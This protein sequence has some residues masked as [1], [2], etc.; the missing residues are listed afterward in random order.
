MT[1]SPVA[2]SKGS[3]G[4]ALLGSRRTE[5]DV[6]E[7]SKRRQTQFC[8][9]AAFWLLGLINNSGYVIMM[10]VA[11]EIAPGAVG[12]VFLADVA[13]TMI[14]KVT[15]PYWFHL[16]PYSLRV[17]TCT[18]LL[19]LSLV[20]VGYGG[21]TAVQLAGVCFSSLQGGLGEA[22]FLALASF[23]DTPRALTAWSSGT[24][25]A[26]IFGYAWVFSLK[27]VLGL[28]FRATLMT[29]NLLGL[30]FLYAYF[31]L[32]SAP[33]GSSGQRRRGV[34]G[35][36]SAAYSPIASSQ[37]QELQSSPSPSGTADGGAR[38][39]SAASSEVVREEQEE[40]WGGGGEGGGLEVEASGV[41]WNRPPNMTVGE[42]LRFTLSLWRF[43]VPLMLVYF[44]EYTMQTGTWSAIGF[45][46]TSADA[47]QRFYEYANW[48]YQGG[49]FVSRSSGMVVRLSPLMLWSLPAVQLFYGNGLLFLCFGVG[50]V[51]GLG[52]V[53]AFR[54]VAEAVPPE[55]KELALASASVGDSFG[56][57]LSD[58]FGT[59]VQA[60]MPNAAAEAHKSAGNAFFKN[61]DYRNAIAKYSDAIAADPTN[62][63]YWSNRS[64]SYA[65]L[66][67]WEE[68][69]RDAAECIKVNKN[70]VKGYFRLAT[71]KKNLNELDAAADVIKRGLCVEP[72][73]A[74]LK[75]NLKEIDELIRGEKVA[76]FISQAEA[77]LKAGDYGAAMR[78]VDAGMR[79][80][81]G[82]SDLKAVMDRAKPKFEAAERSRK[83]GLSSTELLKEKGDDFYKKAS[84]EDA[85]AK[86]TECL[87]SLPD[88]KSEL[89]I[90]CFSNRS[91]CYKQLSNFD[92]TVEDTTSVLE[93]DPNNVKALV[94]RAQAFEAI[95]RYRFALQDVR[96]V[97][98]MPHDKVGSQ[99][100]SLA[101]GMQHRLN[102]VVQQLKNAS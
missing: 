32:L 17:W 2:D 13:P 44:A 8:N 27:F 30:V 15:A 10:A 80:D 79:L 92:A 43:T 94:R 36:T 20:T 9:D 61:G 19:V 29:A 59:F 49:V 47:R 95:E 87:D 57:M 66:N 26:G 102:R 89:A 16:V 55:L 78:A 68:A 21:S 58:V 31:R 1:L 88:K 45:P 98:S 28:S 96:T 23:Y 101:N 41:E 22:S 34:A 93:V 33:H 83:S 60:K 37:G 56:V 38:L 64:A 97:L 77:Q 63:T 54:L 71:A 18:A 25:F 81:A 50:L 46:V 6:L 62:H 52:Y 82:N 86:Y 7:E 84:F 14:I 74:D 91:A 65:G 72:R 76:Q 85:I 67:E 40:E 73:N 48:C 4:T 53:N 42:R 51:G 90:K 99:N 69:A 5:E 75:K 70:F 11:K 12:I 100:L 35:E 24:G 3:I 39:D